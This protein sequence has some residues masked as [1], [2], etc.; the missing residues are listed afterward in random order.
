[1]I[2]LESGFYRQLFIDPLTFLKELYNGKECQTRDE[3]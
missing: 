3:E 2:A 1:M